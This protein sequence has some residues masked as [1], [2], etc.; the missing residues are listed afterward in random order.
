LESIGHRFANRPS[1]HS[2]GLAEAKDP[3]WNLPNGVLPDPIR[4]EDVNDTPCVMKGFFLRD[5]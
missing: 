2:D 5:E 4:Y 1:K 3:G